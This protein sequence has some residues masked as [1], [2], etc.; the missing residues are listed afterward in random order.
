VGPRTVL[1]TGS[2]SRAGI[3]KW[4]SAGLWA[5][6]SV[7]SIPGRFWEIFS[8]PPYPDRLWDPLSLLTYPFPG[9]KAGGE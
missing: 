6:R 8:S 4:Y 2:L 7:G 5:G 1:D 3:A 9:G